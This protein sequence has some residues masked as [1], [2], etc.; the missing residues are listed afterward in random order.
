MEY[1]SLSTKIPRDELTSFK[2]YCNRKGI[3]PSKMLRKLI[4]EIDTPIPNYVAGKN[5]VKYNKK[6][7]KFD[8]IVKSDMGEESHILEEVG[9]EF[10]I[11]LDKQ[12]KEAIKDRNDVLSKMEKKSV[13][14]PS[15]FFK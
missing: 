10:L 5:L 3:T 1:A 13:A 12:I 14:I 11:D 7:D 2:D 15:K 6:K 9:L 4:L 8:W